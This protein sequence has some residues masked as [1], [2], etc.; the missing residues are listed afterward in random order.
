MKHLPFTRLVYPGGLIVDGTPQA[1][2]GAAQKLHARRGWA[3]AL[4]NEARQFAMQHGHAQQMA[5]R[6]MSLLERLLREKRGAKG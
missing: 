3:K 5:D 1:F 4:G 6:Y 2:A